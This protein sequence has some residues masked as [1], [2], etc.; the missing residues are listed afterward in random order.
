[1]FVLQNYIQKL[2]TTLFSQITL[3]SKC[4]KNDRMESFTQSNIMKRKSSFMFKFC[5]F[6][7]SDATSIQKIQTFDES[8]PSWL[9]P[10]LELKD[11]QLGSVRLVAFFNSAR[12]LVEKE[13]KFNSQSKTNFWLSF[14]INLYWKWLNYG[15]KSYFSTLNRTFVLIK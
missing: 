1:M 9:E 8:E 15:A 10:L 7:A 2:G 5:N 3:K 12:K 4:A 14:I 6:H 13:P 11:F